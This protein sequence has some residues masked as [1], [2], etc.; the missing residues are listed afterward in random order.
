MLVSSRL[1][2]YEYQN[3]NI[4]PFLLQ[5]LTLY[6]ISAW[7]LSPNTDFRLFYVAALAIAIGRSGQDPVLKSFLRDQFRIK[8]PSINE[9]RLN[10]CLNACWLTA[11]VLGTII[12]SGLSNVLTWKKKFLV[13]TLVMGANL[14]LFMSGFT[15]YDHEKP[16]KSPFID[17]F[18]VLRAAISKTKRHINYPNEP[19]QYHWE[20]HTPISK[21]H[22]MNDSGQVLLLP[23]YQLFR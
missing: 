1:L 22:D 19:T 23:K 2:P 14:L 21:L 16:T 15:F 20:N 3:N 13:S 7:F 8:N 6:W 4:F 9:K 17:I 12:A 10:C 18:E 5:G 11:C